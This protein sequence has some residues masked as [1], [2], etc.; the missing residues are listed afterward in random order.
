[1]TYS[2]NWPIT[3]RSAIPEIISSH[4]NRRLADENVNCAGS[5][6]YQ[7]CFRLPILN[8]NPKP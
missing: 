3:V 4:Y 2:I 6:I 1:M 7:I 5:A 8:P